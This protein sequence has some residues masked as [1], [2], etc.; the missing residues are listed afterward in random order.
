MKN[1]AHPLLRQFERSTFRLFRL[2]LVCFLLSVVCL[3]P[4][5]ALH[6][7]QDMCRATLDLLE[8]YMLLVVA[9]FRRT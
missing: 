2:S 8:V 3:K 9:M 6:M 1:T 5:S 7:L 4:R